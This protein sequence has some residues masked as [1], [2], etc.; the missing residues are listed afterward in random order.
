MVKSAAEIMCS[1]G[2]DA[3]EYFEEYLKLRKMK[4]KLEAVVRTW[5]AQLEHSRKEC[6][7]NY[8]NALEDC[9]VDI[10]SIL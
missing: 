4:T 5:K 1:K 9:I 3:R 2:E 7:E 10:Q 6:D 8:A